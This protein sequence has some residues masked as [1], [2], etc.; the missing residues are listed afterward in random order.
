M[1]IGGVWVII[2]I[3]DRLVERYLLSPYITDM[4]FWGLYS[5]LPAVILVAWTHGKP[6]KDQSTR[7]EKVGVPINVIA[8]LGLL[9][10]IFGGKDLGATANLVTLNNELGMQEEHYIPRDSYRRRM[11]IF[12]WENE[13]DDSELDWLQY[14]VTELLAQDLWQSPFMLITTAW[15]QQVSGFYNRMPFF[16]NFG[17]HF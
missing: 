3:L 6:G 16:H 7:V 17:N 2:E 12:F 5:L 15:S 14:G 11:A 10:T 13:S 9:I 1:Y 4:A 8:T